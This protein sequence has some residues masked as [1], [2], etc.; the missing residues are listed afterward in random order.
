MSKRL[1]VFE[2]VVPVE[3]ADGEAAEYKEL[4]GDQ[5]NSVLTRALRPHWPGTGPSIEVHGYRI[6]D[7]QIVG[8]VREILDS[9]R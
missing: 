1:F 9:D 2:I 8:V 4:L 6:L 3:Y 7:N 5:L